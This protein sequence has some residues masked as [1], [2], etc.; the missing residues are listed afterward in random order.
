MVRA[1]HV[2]RCLIVDRAYTIAM[3]E[4]NINSGVA[5]GRDVREHLPGRRSGQRFIRDAPALLNERPVF[6]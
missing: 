3:V 5:E 4:L 1:A 6:F 2:G